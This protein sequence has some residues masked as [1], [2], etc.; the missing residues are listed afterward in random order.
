MYVKLL[1]HHRWVVTHSKLHLGM[2]SWNL[3]GIL[4]WGFIFSTPLHSENYFGTGKHSNQQVLLS[5]LKEGQVFLWSSTIQAWMWKSRKIFKDLGE[6]HILT[7]ITAV[8]IDVLKLLSTQFFH[9]IVIKEFADTH[10][11]VVTRKHH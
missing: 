2:A 1:L 9:L 11:K 5:L 7:W 6:L 3:L 4:F 10:C 8:Q